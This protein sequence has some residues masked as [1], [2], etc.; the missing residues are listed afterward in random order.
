MVGYEMLAMP[1][2]DIT[3]EAAAKLLRGVS[4]THYLDQSKA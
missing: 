1:Q 2:R 4:D 3:P